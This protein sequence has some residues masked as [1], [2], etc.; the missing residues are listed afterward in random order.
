MPLR[1]VVG[2]SFPSGL[3]MAV[4]KT[5]DLVQALDDGLSVRLKFC[6]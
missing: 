4:S 5:Q 3:S 2:A 6:R 1:V